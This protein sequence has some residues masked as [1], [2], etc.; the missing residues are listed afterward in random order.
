[1]DLEADF[2]LKLYLNLG[3]QAQRRYDLEWQFLTHELT[4]ERIPAIKAAWLN[5][6]RG[7][8]TKERYACAL[9]K[10]KAIRLARKRGSENVLIFEDDVIL[11]P[12]FRQRLA[13]IDLPEDWGMLYFGCLH[14]RKP[15]PVGPGLVRVD[16]ALDN[17]AFAIHGKYYNRILKA[18][19][20]VP[21]SSSATKFAS[22]KEIM[23]LQ[24]SIPT[25][26]V[27]PNLAWQ[28]ETHSTVQGHSSGMKYSNYAPDGRQLIF[29]EAVSRLEPVLAGLP[30]P[31]LQFTAPYSFSGNIGQ[32]YNEAMGRLAC[33]DDWMVL[34]DLDAMLLGSGVGHQIA[35]IIWK[36]PEYKL[37]AAMTNRIGTN[38][39]KT[40]G[41]WDERDL[42]KHREK[43]LELQSVCPYGVKQ[44]KGPVSGVVLVLQKKTWR[45]VGGF[46]ENGLLHVDY[47]FCNRLLGAGGKI[48]IMEGVYATHYYRMLEGWSSTEHLGY[49]TQ[50]S[51]D[52]G[53]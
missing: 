36:H 40:P 23:F 5:Q 51:G 45:D 14:V 26:A 28:A 4:V 31:N 11:H 8:S 50:G 39:Q 22:D 35:Q 30:Q 10:A 25:Y 49:K 24:E 38:A 17:H 16:Q 47:D 27:W 37:F 43:S 15:T 42:G 46:A 12:E 48:G 33:D 53:K 29:R 1:M 9:S 34:M 41:M 20:G 18:I 2:P 13:E 6:K 3:N 44:T 52:A 32:A 21:K 19:H 7:Y